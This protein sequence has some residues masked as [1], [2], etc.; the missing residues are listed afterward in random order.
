MQFYTTW[1]L[2][3]RNAFHLV[4]YF[5]GTISIRTDLRQLSKTIWAFTR[6]LL[7]AIKTL[8]RLLLT[9]HKKICYLTARVL[10]DRF[11]K[12]VYAFK[13]HRKRFAWQSRGA[14][15]EQMMVRHTKSH[16]YHVYIHHT[17]LSFHSE[18]KYHLY[19]SASAS[20]KSLVSIFTSTVV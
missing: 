19:V 8:A 10:P 17:L 7:A 12:S 4:V 2:M 20:M 1:E 13:G 16:K 14:L 11:P 6:S 15:N 3:G 9:F 5:A 18:V